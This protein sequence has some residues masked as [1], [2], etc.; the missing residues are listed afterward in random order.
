MTSVAY[1]EQQMQ[2][3]LEERANVVVREVGCIVRQ[4][5][6]S[7]ADVVQT[8][9]F[10]FG[11]HPHASLEQL[12]STA[13]V[14]AVSVSDTAVHDRFT[15]PSARLLHRMVEEVSEVVV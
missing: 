8:L 3:I 15:E 12:A 6:F 11:Q 7:G 5:K 4:R 10:G 1:V 9:L 13:A 2:R 14:R